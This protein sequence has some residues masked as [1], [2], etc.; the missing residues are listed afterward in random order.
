MRARRVGGRLSGI[1]GT[2]F[3]RDRHI[4][5]RESFRGWARVESAVEHRDNLTCRVARANAKTEHE[6]NRKR[7]FK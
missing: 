5:D 4:A 6:S 7:A 2:A 3:V 1:R